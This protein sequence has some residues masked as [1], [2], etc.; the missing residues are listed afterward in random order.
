MTDLVWSAKVLLHSFF[1]SLTMRFDLVRSIY[2]SELLIEKEAQS[3]DH[4]ITPI[5]RE[6]TIGFFSTLYIP[7]FIHYIDL[8]DSVSQSS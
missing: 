7:P 6:I 5:N 8:I 4:S 1:P 3:P 2:F